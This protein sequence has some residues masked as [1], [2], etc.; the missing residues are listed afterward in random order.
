MPRKSNSK[1]ESELAC[2][3]FLSIISAELEN[4]KWTKTRLAREMN[5]APSNVTQIFQKRDLYLSTM[6]QLA[7]ALGMT[8]S[9]EYVVEV[10]RITLNIERRTNHKKESHVV[11]YLGGGK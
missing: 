9:V 4:R 8:I 6:G 7:A 3:D 11:L 2:I 1:I 5:C 10:N